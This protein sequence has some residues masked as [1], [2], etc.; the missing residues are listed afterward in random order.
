MGGGLA[1]KVAK[2]FSLYSNATYQFALNNAEG[3]KRDGINAT[4]GLR[5]TW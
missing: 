5:F 2:N 4:V 3:Q 1:T